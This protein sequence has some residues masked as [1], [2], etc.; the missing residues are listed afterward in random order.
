[1]HKKHV[2]HIWEIFSRLRKTLLYIKLS[3]YQ[4]HI[5]EIEFL[6]YYIK[7]ADILMNFCKISI[8]E[9]WQEL[10]NFHDI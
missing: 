1:M 9:E 6:K 2:T 8:I 7:V 5:Q 10:Q 4:F 3:K